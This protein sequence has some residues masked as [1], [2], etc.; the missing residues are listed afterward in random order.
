MQFKAPFQ[1]RPIT[2]REISRCLL[3]EIKVTLR[4]IETVAIKRMRRQLTMSANLRFSKI[5]IRRKREED[6][7][8]KPLK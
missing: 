7:L 3:S 4:R 2:T 8:K 1:Q 5:C 6:T